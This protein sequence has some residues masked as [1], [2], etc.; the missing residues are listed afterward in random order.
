MAFSP[1]LAFF[2]LTVTYIFPV[3]IEFFVASLRT[4]GALSVVHLSTELFYQKTMSVVTL[5]DLCFLS[6]MKKG[7]EER[8]REKKKLNAARKR[9]NAKDAD[10]PR[11]NF[12]VPGNCF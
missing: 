11:I 2:Q 10:F 5:R 12:S 1:K 8:E 3:E 4:P 9:P 6:Q 7:E